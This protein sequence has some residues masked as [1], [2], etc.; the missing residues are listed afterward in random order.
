MKNLKLILLFVFMA[1]AIQ[2]NAT[3]YI[4]IHV[5]FTGRIRL[6]Y[7]SKPENLKKWYYDSKNDIYY[8]GK[9]YCG[10]PMKIKF[11]IRTS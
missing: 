9:N 11:K 10:I 2:A 1:F 8:R 6:I 5:G 7:V 4:I 3:Q